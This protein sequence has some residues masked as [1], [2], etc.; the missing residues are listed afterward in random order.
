MCYPFM[1]EALMKRQRYAWVTEDSQRFVL[2]QQ[3]EEA[4]DRYYLKF[5]NGWNLDRK[6]VSLLRDLCAWRE[7][8]ARQMDTPRTRI[9]RDSSLFEIAEKQPSNL[10]GLL[11]LKSLQ[12]KTR[13]I[14]HVKQYAHQILAHVNVLDEKTD[15]TPPQP[16]E[17]PLERDLK[18]LFKACKAL[19]SD[20]AAEHEIPQERLVSKNELYR[21]VA[22]Y[23]HHLATDEPVLLPKSMQGWRKCIVV[24]PLCELLD[25]YKRDLVERYNRLMRKAFRWQ[26]ENESPN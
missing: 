6:Q 24:E 18:Q 26:Q 9:V 13:D 5:R 14:R 3:K 22:A 23:A 17:P 1:K 19:I 25:P 20:I 15:Q 11:R 2:D 8:V 12:G 4:F 16:I 7:E 21:L 10:K